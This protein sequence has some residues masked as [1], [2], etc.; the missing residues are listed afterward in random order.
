MRAITALLLAALCTG[1]LAEDWLVASATSYHF[2]TEKHYNQFNYGVGFE[3]ATSY[4]RLAVVAGEYQNSLD[5]TS[6][7]AGLAWTPVALLGVHVGFIGG[8][9]TGY[10]S[11]PVIPMLLPAAQIEGRHVGVNF[12]YAPKIKDGASVL[13][14]Q[15]KWAP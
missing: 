15:L 3:K 13:G 9:L 10:T 12:F 5:R 7:Y 14:L 11:H 2:S 8:A 4:P 1:A 6:A